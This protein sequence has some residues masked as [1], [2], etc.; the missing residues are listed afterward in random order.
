MKR[1]DEE[2]SPS[3]ALVPKKRKTRLAGKV[4]TYLWACRQLPQ[5]K[6]IVLPTAFVKK[7]KMRGSKPNGMNRCVTRYLLSSHL[8]AFA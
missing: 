5:L 7:K 6:P 4:R 1:R 3:D 2:S 8:D